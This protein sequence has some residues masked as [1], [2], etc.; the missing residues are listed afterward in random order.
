MRAIGHHLR[1]VV[2]IGETG[3]GTGA[4]EELERALRDH[5]LIKIKV[6]IGD[7]TLRR[8]VVA[9]LADELGAE[10]VQQIGKVA[11]VYRANPEAK[12]RLSNVARAV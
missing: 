11:L 12:A 7:R 5:E 2:T 4:R 3:A 6:Q 10:L 8:E 9:A 1:P